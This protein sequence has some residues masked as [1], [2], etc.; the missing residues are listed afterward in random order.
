MD[1]PQFVKSERAKTGLSQDR[2]ARLLDLPLKT[3]H[4]WEQGRGTP[5]GSER[6]LRAGIGKMV[7]DF[8]GRE[9]PQTHPL[10]GLTS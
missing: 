10:A 7:M 8:L 2:F 3:L 6:I 4:N 5:P 9:R 1:W